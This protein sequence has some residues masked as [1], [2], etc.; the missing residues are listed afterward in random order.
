MLSYAGGVVCA[1]SCSSCNTCL[2]FCPSLQYRLA[3]CNVVFQSAVF[4]PM[5]PLLFVTFWHVRAT[6]RLSP[7]HAL[8][9]SP[10]DALSEEHYE[11]NEEYEEEEE[12]GNELEEDE[13]ASAPV[14]APRPPPPPP[15]HLPVTPPP[16]TAR[17]GMTTVSR[18]VVVKHGAGGA[19][20]EG[21]RVRVS[22]HLERQGLTDAE[23]QL[24]SQWY[25][26]RVPNDWR[27]LRLAMA[28]AAK[29]CWA[30]ARSCMLMCFLQLSL[31][32][33][34][35]LPSAGVRSCTAAFA[36]HHAKLKLLLHASKQTD[37][38]VIA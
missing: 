17:P 29:A 18:T 14:A 19:G 6:T 9:P 10:P 32:G 13:G 27:T 21:G 37:V 16:P 23:A 22:L 7:C 38:L 20:G 5:L 11:D 26:V 34:L 24:L 30:C 3:V 31:L 4:C 15:P 25:E 36:C 33:T 2:C 8:L 12:G 35:Q 1:C 28:R